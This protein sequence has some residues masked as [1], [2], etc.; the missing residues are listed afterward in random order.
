MNV[1]KK[2]LTLLCGSV[3]C[4]CLRWG[5]VGTISCYSMDARTTTYKC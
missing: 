1:L 4:V 3:I 2:S 5:G